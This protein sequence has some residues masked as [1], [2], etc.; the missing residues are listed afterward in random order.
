MGR[1]KNGHQEI[2]AKH[3]EID[4]RHPEIYTNIKGSIQ[5]SRDLRML[6]PRDLQ[7]FGPKFTKQSK[8]T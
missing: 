1:K 4:A 3:Q 7:M 2:Y 5:I 6:K 8:S